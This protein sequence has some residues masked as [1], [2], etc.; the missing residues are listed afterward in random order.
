MRRAILAPLQAVT[1]QLSP[2]EHSPV[3][4]LSVFSDETW[5]FSTEAAD[6]SKQFSKQAIRWKFKLTQERDSLAPEYASTLL[7][8]KQLAYLMLSSATRMKPISVVDRIMMLKIFIRF[9][10][11]RQS[12]IFRFQ[13]VLEFH[14]KEY[15]DYLKTR[16]GRRGVIHSSVL[17]H[18]LAALNLLHDYRDQLSD[19]LSFRPTGDRPPSKIAGYRYTEAWENRT[20]PIPDQELKI[21]LGWAGALFPDTRSMPMRPDAKSRPGQF[22]SCPGIRLQDQ[23]WRVWPGI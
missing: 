14:I 3:S 12:P 5:D 6:T 17:C 7:A 2:N 21:T 20:Q 1:P 9:L 4:A 13:D 23:G 22:C 8:L 15:I 18:H 10:A 19:Y 11:E 16:P